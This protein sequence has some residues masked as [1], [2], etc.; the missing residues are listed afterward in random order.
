MMLEQ[1]AEL[2][3]EVMNY[4][5]VRRLCY[6]GGPEGILIGLPEEVGKNE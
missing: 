2:V 1:G 3:G 5:D 6:I 4:P